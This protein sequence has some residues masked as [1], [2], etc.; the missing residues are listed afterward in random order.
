MRPGVL[1]A[2]I[3]SWAVCT[4]GRFTAPFLEDVAHFNESMIGFAFGL[5]IFFGTIFASIGSKKADQL[6]LRYPGKGRLMLLMALVFFGNLGF[7]IHFLVYHYYFFKKNEDG[8]DH[9]DEEGL[10]QLSIDIIGKPNAIFINK[11]EFLHIIARILFSICSAVVH[12]IL[13]GISLAYL[14][15]TN[16][17]K[18]QGDYGK[19]RL[20]GAVSWAIA[21]IL[22]GPALDR[23]GYLDTF[24]WASSSSSIICL[25]VIYLYMRS[26]ASTQSCTADSGSMN[27]HRQIEIV[28]SHDDEEETDV[29]DINQN[30]AIDSSR[31]IEMKD[32]NAN[33][34][35]S[36]NDETSKVTQSDHDNGDDNDGGDGSLRILKS[37][38]HT[39]AGV[40]FIISTVSLSMGTSIVENLIFLFFQELGASSAICGASV[41]VTVIFEVPI[42]QYSG[43]IL[44]KLGAEALQKIACFAYVI[45][46]VGYT[47]IPQDHVALI[48]LFEPLHGVTYACSKTSSV[49]F[50]SKLSPSGFESTGQGVMTLL[51]GM[52]VI[53]GLSMGGWIED[54]FSAVTLYRSYAVVVGVGLVIFHIATYLDSSRQKDIVSYSIVSKQY[55]ASIDDSS[56]VL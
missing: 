44:E 28:A 10:D 5:Q 35:S 12:P 22:V 47:F 56:S 38:F 15:E 27:I 40:G 52:G 18:E 36:M 9:D 7:Q 37:M 48:L 29:A 13:D 23:Y 41:V 3:F 19:E 26:Q 39:V 45:R 4:G 1:Y 17:N 53:F 31:E 11:A 14:K 20:F 16:A 33:H 25:F 54:T 50:A 51:Q 42:F 49:E 24:F 43:Q 34:M 55:A 2:A 8:H 21:S 30:K 32:F 6:E 46:V